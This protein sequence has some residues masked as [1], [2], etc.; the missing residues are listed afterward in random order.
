MVR[1]GGGRKRGKLLRE[2][3]KNAKLSAEKQR[4]PVWV[5]IV[6]VQKARKGQLRPRERGQGLA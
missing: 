4:E 2:G 3:G 6:R 1:L 5:V